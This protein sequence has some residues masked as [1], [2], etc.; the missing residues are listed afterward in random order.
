MIQYATDIAML[1]LKEDPDDVEKKRKEVE[2]KMKDV[3]DF[4]EKIS[5]V[6]A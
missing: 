2:K 1:T 5:K 4:E 3:F 6:N